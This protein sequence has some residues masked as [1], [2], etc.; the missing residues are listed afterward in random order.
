VSPQGK[1]GNPAAAARKKTPPPPKSRKGLG[2]I[3]FGVTFVALFV[4]V[5]VAVGIGHPSVPEGSIAVVEDAPGGPIT[6]QEYDRALA[7][8][9]AQQGLKAVPATTDPSF[10]QLSQAA[11]SYLI[12]GR[13]VNGE[14]EERG[15]EISDREIDDELNKVKTQQFDSEKAFQKFL[16]DSSYT[17]DEVRA[18]IRLQLISNKIQTAVLPTSPTVSDDEIQAF[19]DANAAQFK[20][21]ESRDVR[22]ILTKTQADADAALAALQKDDSP[23]SFTAVAKKYSIDEA[24]KAS[25]GLRPG[26]VQGSSEAALDTQIFGAQQGALVGPFKG[27][28]GYYVIEVQKITPA[29]TQSLSDPI[30]AATAGAPAQT[31]SDQIR[32]TLVSAHQQDIA[33]AFQTNFQTKWTQRTFCADGY[34]IDRCSNAEPVPSTCTA[35]VA[36]KQGCPAPVVSNRPKAPGTVEVFGVTPA[37]P[38]APQGPIGSAPASVDNL[39]PG[40]QSVPPGG[41]PPG[42]VPPQGAAPATP[43]APAPGG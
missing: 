39:P 21:P 12:L 4:I 17:L 23:D 36:A 9:A 22:V 14:A 7:Q 41:V 33:T 35:E 8:F 30:A 24:T 28:A 37:A 6:K 29:V 10:A 34:R 26:V 40:L 16:T 27:Q 38:P 15:I 32:Q 25:G 20:Q 31:V 19:Y 1:K 13:W 5:G 43:T 3:L 11:E 42:T 18:R 2:L